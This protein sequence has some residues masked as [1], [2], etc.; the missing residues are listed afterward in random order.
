MHCM[1]QGDRSYV[2][3]SY[4][5]ATLTRPWSSLLYTRGAWFFWP[6]CDLYKGLTAFIKMM[7]TAKRRLCVYVPDSAPRLVRGTA[8]RGSLLQGGHC[9]TGTFG[10]VYVRATFVPGMQQW[11][12]ILAARKQT[13]GVMCELA[14]STSVSADKD[15]LCVAGL[16]VEM[17]HLL[18]YPSDGIYLIWPCPGLPVSPVVVGRRCRA[19]A[20]WSGAESGLESKA[21]HGPVLWDAF[22]HN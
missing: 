16:G 19:G 20:A 2:R 18:W 12:V 3:Y 22:S 11:K 15:T 21:C 5:S 4:A 9:F 8:S 17:R 10:W 7:I 6:L 14:P 13:V 1:D